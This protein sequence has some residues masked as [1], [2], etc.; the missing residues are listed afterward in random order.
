MT[1]SARDEKQP[2]WGLGAALGIGIGVA[3]SVAL[4]NWAFV[5]IGVAFMPLVAYLF[6]GKSDDDS[7]EE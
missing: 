6:G 4:D 7:A 3:L 2:N 5:G 1:D